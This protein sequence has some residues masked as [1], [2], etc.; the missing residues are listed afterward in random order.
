MRAVEW[1]A[2]E[3]TL[4][5]ATLRIVAIPVLP[6]REKFTGRWYMATRAGRLVR[7]PDLVVL[8]RHAPGPDGPG[9]GSVTHAVLSHAHGPVISVPGD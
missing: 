5:K 6:Q 9:V 2:R 8:G 3:A 1:A 4:R 7:P